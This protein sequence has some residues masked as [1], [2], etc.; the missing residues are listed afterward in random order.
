MKKYIPVLAGVLLVSGAVG[1]LVFQPSSTS[2]IAPPPE[3]QN[4][5][6]QVDNHEGRITTLETAS[7][8]TPS[9]VVINTT[10]TAQA[11][12]QAPVAS[13]APAPDPI[14][15]PTPS[16]VATPVTTPS[17]TPDHVPG[18]H[19]VGQPDL[20]GYCGVNVWY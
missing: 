17:P 13:A 5:Q 6:A 9:P 11:P 15:T 3:I 20:D 1:S 16:P 12:A 4:L 18:W 19:C 7:G 10:T 8:I 14:A 2:G